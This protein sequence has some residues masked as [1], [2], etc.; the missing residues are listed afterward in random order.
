MV[1][2][3]FPACFAS[4]DLS[5]AHEAAVVKLQAWVREVHVCNI[6]TGLRFAQQATLQDAQQARKAA[7]DEVGSCA[8]PG[9]ENPQLASS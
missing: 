9:Y 5:E 3:C 8:T 1:D 4:L 7:E 2:V 6:T